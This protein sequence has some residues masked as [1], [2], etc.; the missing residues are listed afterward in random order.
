LRDMFIALVAKPL[1]ER[2]GRA[3]SVTLLPRIPCLN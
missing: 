3:L 2:S 1:P